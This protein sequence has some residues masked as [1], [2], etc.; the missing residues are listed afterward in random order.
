MYMLW[1]DH[2][3]HDI[4]G[5][6]PPHLLQNLQKEIARTRRPQQR[7]S[8]IAAEGDEMQIPSAVITFQFT[9]HKEQ[10][11]PPFPNPGKGRAPSCQRSAVKYINGMLCSYH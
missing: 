7:P 3:T 4:R 1:H 10:E 11:C 5:T 9:R 6:A 8:L 2:E